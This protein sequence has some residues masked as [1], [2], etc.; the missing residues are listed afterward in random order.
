MTHKKTI[1]I[2]DDQR[3][4]RIMLSHYLGAQYE[5]IQ[6]EC[7]KDAVETLQKGVKADVIISDI[8]MPEMDG[9]EFLVAYQKQ[10]KGN[11][12]PVIILSG[13]E[14]SAERLKC[15]KNGA[16]DFLVKPFNPE[17]LDFRIRNVLAT[18]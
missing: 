18:N 1:M 2:I 3:S 5:V 16:R 17:E 4:T 13:V 10:Q 7:A 14:N 9:L 12:S 15:F 11:A 6:R 8:L